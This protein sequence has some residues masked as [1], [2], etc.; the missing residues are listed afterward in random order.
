[1][2]KTTPTKKQAEAPETVSGYFRRILT[3]NRKLLRAR[4]ND[5]L[6]R[7]WQADHPGEE[8]T[9][10]LRAVLMNVKSVLRHS[11]RKRRAGKAGQPQ[12]QA[13]TTHEM[14]RPAK[15]PRHLEALEEQ[16]DDCLSTAKG[17][18]RDGLGDVI[19]LLRRARNG[20]VWKMG[21]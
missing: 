1:M 9:P 14:P 12:E 5:E 8:F 13:V 18:D 4:S 16:I 3:E 6:V 17:L 11:K 21:E 15:P 20:V 10:K 7:R 2:A 19:V